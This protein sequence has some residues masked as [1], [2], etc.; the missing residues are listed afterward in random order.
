MVEPEEVG[1]AGHD[2]NC[3]QLIK[4]SLWPR[5]DLIIATDPL[6]VALFYLTGHSVYGK[7]ISAQHSL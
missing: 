4:R 2:A 6:P 1:G 3:S 7:F 5:R